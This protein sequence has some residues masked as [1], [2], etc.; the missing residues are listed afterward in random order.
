MSWLENNPLGLA[1]AAACG[2]LIMGSVALMLAWGKPV[3]SGAD[4][5]PMNA[6]LP[7]ESGQ[8]ENELEPIAAYRIVTERPVFEESRRPA[9]NVGD[10][11]LELVNDPGPEVGDAPKVT[12]KGVVISPEFSM[13]TLQP[14]AGGESLIAHEGQPLEGDYAG[15]IVSD[16]KPRRITL[17]SLDGRSTELDLEVNTRKIAEP[18]RPEPAP[19]PAQAV[20]A[21]DNGNEGGEDQP[22]S[23]AEEIRQRIA[24]RREELA[25]QAEANQPRA[26]DGT[27]QRTE[28]QSAIRNMINK[29]KNEEQESEGDGGKKDDG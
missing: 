8:P 22:M 14:E 26:A 6:E 10:E 20:A 2:V 28:Y 17:A 24:E 4:S 23:R 5:R 7:A 13:V 1:L 18:P 9:V 11:G 25:R 12:L 29:R 15:W 3:T 19:E 21:A 16:I 27:A